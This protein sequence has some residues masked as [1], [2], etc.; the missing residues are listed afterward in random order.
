MTIF[1]LV[2]TA[3]PLLDLFVW[4]LDCLFVTV[5]GDDA[6]VS[7]YVT[8]CGLDNLKKKFGLENLMA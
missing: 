5:F 7:F 3:D 6:H 8:H 2:Q 4:D 1:G